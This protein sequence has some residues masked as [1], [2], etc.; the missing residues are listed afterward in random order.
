LENPAINDRILALAGKIIQEHLPTFETRRFD[1]LAKDLGVTLE[2]VT[3]AVKLITSLDPKPGRDFGE[4]DVRYVTEDVYVHKVGDEWVVTLNEEGLPRLKVSSSYRRLLA[5][6]GEAKDYIQDKLRAAA[7]L[8][9]SIHQRQRTLLLVAQ[10][11]AKFQQD[12]LTYGVSHMRPLILR[13]VADDV[14]IHESTVSRAISNKYIATPRGTYPLKKFF[15]TGLKGRQGPD[16]ASESV[17][18]RIR[19]MINHEDPVHPLSDEEIAQ[20][21]SRDDV[22]I[23]RRTVAKYRESMNILPSAK[24]K[25]LH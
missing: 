7:W 6:G 3:Q 11:L 5:E 19:E 15:T 9:K 18:E 2:E 14:G 17:K 13:D 23:A 16:V 22:T 20:V 10:S 4:G 21:L 25:Q 8:I 12:F 1:R 24:R